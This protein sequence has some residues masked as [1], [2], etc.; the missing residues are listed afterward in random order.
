MLLRG[1]NV[2][3]TRVVVFVRPKIRKF[4]SL[5]VLLLI[6]YV[7]TYLLLHL[8]L[9]NLWLSTCSCCPTGVTGIS[10][11]IP[12]RKHDEGPGE[13]CDSYGHTG[14]GYGYYCSS[15]SIS[16][17]TTTG[18]SKTPQDEHA[19][20]KLIAPDHPPPGLNAIRTPRYSLCDVSSFSPHPNTTTTTRDAD[21]FAVHGFPIPSFTEPTVSFNATYYS[22]RGNIRATTTPQTN[23]TTP[24]EFDTIETV[25]IIVHGSGRNAEDYF[26]AGL[27]LLNNHNNNNSH[28]IN[29]SNHN[30]THQN[31]LVL[32]PKF[33]VD[34]D[35]NTFKE[36]DKPL[37]WDDIDTDLGIKNNYGDYDYD[38]DYD[39][40]DENI[41]DTKTS[42]SSTS[43]SS[44]KDTIDIGVD[45]PLYWAEIGPVPHS[46]HTWRYVRSVRRV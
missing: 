34:M 27:S 39:Y 28:D 6:F 26:C 36:A 25:L 45:N 4:G 10:S 16:T 23:T 19:V 33:L 14:C 17:T 37:Y 41:D 7:T 1:N 3:Q 12:H 20:C 38:Y 21:V 22:N 44:S 8:V 29:T 2:P 5:C 9:F 24:T 13:C 11:C 15:S 43:T 30:H 35:L 42:S 18:A 46:E 31:T 32:A 40:E